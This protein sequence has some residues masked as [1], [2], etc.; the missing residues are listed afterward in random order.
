MTEKKEVKPKAKS[1]K[2]D[3]TPIIARMNYNSIFIKTVVFL[4]SFKFIQVKGHIYMLIFFLLLMLL[5][6]YYLFLER[7][8]RLLEKVSDFSNKYIAYLQCFSSPSIYLYY[9]GILVLY[10]VQFY[11]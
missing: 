4:S 6:N 11:G 7:K 8:T 3:V 5:D 2:K 9:L 1:M 10:L